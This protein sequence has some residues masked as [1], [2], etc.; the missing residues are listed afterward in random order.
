MTSRP[1]PAEG[2]HQDRRLPFLYNPYEAAVTGGTAD[3]RRALVAALAQGPLA[4]LRPA[5]VHLTEPGESAL[6][7]EVFEGERR[8][9]MAYPPLA[10]EVTGAPP[11]LDVDA[12]LI[13]S[14]APVPAPSLCFA[15]SAPAETEQLLA[16]VGPAEACPILPANTPYYAGD[17]VEALADAIRAHWRRQTADTPLLGLVLAGGESRRMGRDK[18][19]MDYHGVDQLEW[20]ARMLECVCQEVFVSA[21]PGACASTERPV[22][23]DSVLDAGP[24][25]GILSALRARPNAAWLIAACDMPFLNE[26]T[27]ADL[28]GGRNPFRLATA[29]RGP[30][31]GAPEPLCAIYEPKAIFR[32]MRFL[33]A[34]QKCPR[35]ALMLSRPALLDPPDPCALRNVNHPREAEAARQRITGRREAPTP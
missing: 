22:V 21:R 27:L 7:A 35:R 8:R 31:D 19:R 28:R 3:R 2:R 11:L 9:V 26:Q 6:S 14:E 30:R 25:G 4:D 29:F 18:A 15:P 12:V 34:G 23:T 1:A 17:D 33:A 32:L 24:L 16:C 5:V 10:E 13:D 20:T